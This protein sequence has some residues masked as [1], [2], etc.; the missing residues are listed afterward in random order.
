MSQQYTGHIQVRPL[1]YT[2]A[3]ICVSLYIEATLIYEYCVI[4][5]CLFQEPTTE[6]MTPC[7]Y[8]W[9]VTA[10]SLCSRKFKTVQHIFQDGVAREG[11]Q[12]G[13][14][15]PIGNFSLLVGEKIKNLSGN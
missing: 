1:N 8:V 4:R 5:V 10:S 7:N 2:P 12:R 9:A 15:P 3:V 11:A 13:L 6:V 14:Q